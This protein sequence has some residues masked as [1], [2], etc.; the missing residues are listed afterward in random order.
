[1]GGSEKFF[2]A[3]PKKKRME[4]DKFN[5]RLKFAI[6]YPD[7]FLA[8]QDTPGTHR[9]D[10]RF[11]PKGLLEPKEGAKGYGSS[12]QWPFDYFK[13]LTEPGYR[14]GI[15]RALENSAFNSVW[16]HT[17]REWMKEVEVQLATWD[18]IRDEDQ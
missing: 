2:L 5:R 17:A 8:Q 11:R 18:F 4:R 16:R 7:A 12:E 3:R 1:L 6:Q 15:S 10:V 14:R 13:A 9:P